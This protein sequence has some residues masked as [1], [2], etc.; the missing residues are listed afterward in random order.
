MWLDR[1]WRW[2]LVVLR[3]FCNRMFVPKSNWNAW[4]R[5]ETF[6]LKKVKSLTNVCALLCIQCC[7]KTE[8]F[9]TP[10]STQKNYP[11]WK[12][13]SF[14]GENGENKEDFYLLWAENGNGNDFG[15]CGVVL[16]EKSLRLHLPLTYHLLLPSS[17][18]VF[19]DPTAYRLL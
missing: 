9:G 5:L 16:Q 12:A 3:L 19:F 15:V 7:F 1:I 8:D 4:I 10:E 13:E 6:I 17:I 11:K 14:D 2:Q 18:L